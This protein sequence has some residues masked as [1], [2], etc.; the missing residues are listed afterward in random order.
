MGHSH[1]DAISAAMHKVLMHSVS[2]LV[3][4]NKHRP[5]H[6]CERPYLNRATV[7][8][9]PGLRLAASFIELLCIVALCKHNESAS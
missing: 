9:A 2:N 3:F 1:A 5:K 8:T 6:C 7:H 4:I